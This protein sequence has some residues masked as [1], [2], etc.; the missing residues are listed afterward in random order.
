MWGTTARLAM[1]AVLFLLL[2][3]P[4]VDADAQEYDSVE[5]QICDRFDA[6]FPGDCAKAVAVARCEGWNATAN[7]DVAHVSPTSDV[8]PFQINQIH[9]DNPQGVLRVLFGDDAR[10]PGPA[11]TLDGNI[12]VALH[13]RGLNGWSDWAN[14]AGCHGGIVGGSA[15]RGPTLAFTGAD[16]G[17]AAVGLV[18]VGGGCVVLGCM[19]G[20]VRT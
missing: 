4:G 5:Q 18:L 11:A 8:G 15:A 19:R 10:W 7:F 14:S 9:D 6:E 20:K 12:T 2:N 13:L 1:G 16:T 3:A 17:L